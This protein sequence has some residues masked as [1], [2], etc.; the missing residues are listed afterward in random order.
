MAERL[1]ESVGGRVAYRPVDRPAPRVQDHLADHRSDREDTH[2]AACLD[3]GARLEEH[4]HGPDPGQR[5]AVLDPSGYPRCLL[6]REE[7]ARRGGLDLGHALE[8]VLQLM[9]VVEAPAVTT[10]SSISNG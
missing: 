1:E 2:R 4:G 3:T 10:S 9:K 7:I 8:G 5:C 6:R